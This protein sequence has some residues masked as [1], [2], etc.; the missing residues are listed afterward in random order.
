VGVADGRCNVSEERAEG[1]W[2]VRWSGGD[3]E[4][5]T[6]ADG[7]VWRFHQRED[8][9]V[10]ADNIEWGPYLGKEPAEAG[11]PK[12]GAQPPPW[13]DSK[14][15]SFEEWAFARDKVAAEQA[16]EIR[17]LRARLEEP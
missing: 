11:I 1:F 13:G 6:V 9:H 15:S 5:V 16:A 14:E 3:W 7:G 2:W 4:V 10:D 17:R 12:A 8:S